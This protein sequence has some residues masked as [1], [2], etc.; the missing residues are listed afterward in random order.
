[1]SPT[2]TT[3]PRDELL[4]E[5]WVRIWGIPEM[6]FSFGQFSMPFMGGK[7][8]ERSPWVEC[9]DENPVA[10]RDHHSECRILERTVEYRIP[11]LFLTAHIFRNIP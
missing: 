2:V 9:P 6:G 5:P 10:N 7:G 4:P 3:S 1:M 11:R 8:L